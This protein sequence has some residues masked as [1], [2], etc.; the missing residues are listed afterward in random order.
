MA[1]NTKDIGATPTGGTKREKILSLLK[2]HY[3]LFEKENV[4][5]P[6]F[7]PRLCYNHKG[8]KIIGFYRKEIY[9]GLNIYIEFCSRDYT[10]EDPNRTLW[11]WIYNPEYDTE[12]EQSDPHPATKDRRYLIPIEE[13][14]NVTEFHSIKSVVVE[15]TE[16]TD[17]QVPVRGEPEQIKEMVQDTVE[18]V[19]IV[20]SVETE[21]AFVFKEEETAGSDVPYSA[22]TLRDYAAIKWK[23]PI[24]PRDWLNKLIIK[25][26]GE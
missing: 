20:D 4:T 10:P 2:H 19:E 15:D 12:Y 24:S 1:I 17:G 6:K 16:V 21:L 8:E 14:I 9:G 25:N 5:N 3:E 13:L 22:M 11:K 7:I 23:K 18:K 26:F